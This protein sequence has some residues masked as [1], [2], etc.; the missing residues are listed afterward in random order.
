M[1]CGGSTFT[2]A[3]AA[4]QLGVS[5]TTVRRLVNEGTLSVRRNGRRV[6]IC[7]KSLD[8]ERGRREMTAQRLTQVDRRQ[9]LT[10][11]GAVFA[12]GVSGW[13]T[14]VW[15]R[16]ARFGENRVDV[17][18]LLPCWRTVQVSVGMHHTV[19]GYHPDTQEALQTIAP[20]IVRSDR[21]IV[22]GSDSFPTV[23]P[24]R[25]LLLIGGPATNLLSRRLHG[26][27]SVGKKLSERPTL[28]TG[29]R[30]CFFYP[31]PSEH[32][33][34]FSRYVRGELR[35]TMSKALLDCRAQ[36]LLAEPRYC[37]FEKTH[38]RVLSDFLLLTVMPNKLE[39]HA[40]GFYV[41]DVADLHGQGNKVF[42][43]IVGDSQR[44]KELSEAV[45]RK[46]YF[47]A[48]YEVPVMHSPIHCKTSPGTPK[49]LDVH[50]LG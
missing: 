2:I 33:P 23:D 31:Q 4:S 43:R 12:S 49:L 17:E 39:N 46:R 3:Q 24:Y 16:L 50:V 20:H 48:L 19:E 42:A 1:F 45:G 6:L 29:L 36:G 9:L 13:M 47:Q 8:S 15:D 18:E 41:I 35:R 11:I 37:R 14:F 27:S 44:R 34:D 5:K 26:Y 10:V 40:S 7:A 22:D 32:D 28:S 21:V 25:D 30:W 38:G